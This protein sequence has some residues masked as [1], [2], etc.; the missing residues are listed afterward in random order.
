MFACG[1][2]HALDAPVT[3]VAA[4][5]S[6]VPAAPNLEQIVLPAVEDVCRTIEE[7]PRY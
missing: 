7:V 1:S 2:A 3:R 4:R 5:D 6:F